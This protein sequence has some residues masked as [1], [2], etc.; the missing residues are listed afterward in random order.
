MGARAIDEEGERQRGRKPHADHAD[1]F[2]HDLALPRTVK[3][4][5]ENH[6]DGDRYD[7]FT[8][9]M[10]KGDAIVDS[11]IA[12]GKIEELAEI[13]AKI[14]LRYFQPEIEKYYNTIQ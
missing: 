2:E 12:A 14:Y 3:V 10:E 13:S 7:D 1:P 9:R 4:R 5:H 8:I 11:L 6:P